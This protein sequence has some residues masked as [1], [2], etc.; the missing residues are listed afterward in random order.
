MS[1]PHLQDLAPGDA[2]L[3]APPS[4]QAA[5]ARRWILTCFPPETVPHDQV[6]Y[7]RPVADFFRTHLL[8]LPKEVKAFTAAVEQAPTTGRWHL[9]GCFTLKK[10]TRMGQVKRLILP[11]LQPHLVGTSRGG[12][13]TTLGTTSGDDGLDSEGGS[14]D[15]V[16]KSARV[17]FER[18]DR[19]ASLQPPISK[20]WAD[21]VVEDRGRR[22]SCTSEAWPEGAEWRRRNGGYFPLFPPEV[23][24]SEDKGPVGTS[25][26]GL[27]EDD[28]ASSRYVR[29]SLAWIHASESQPY[30]K[31]N[32][33]IRRGA[34]MA[35][36]TAD[37]DALLRKHWLG[38]EPTGLPDLRD[39]ISGRGSALGDAPEGG[40]V[41]AELRAT[42]RSNLGRVSSIPDAVLE[43]ITDDA[44][45]P[46]DSGG[47]G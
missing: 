20:E 13:L 40:Q 3:R 35:G 29:N 23:K 19:K 27:H 17:L 32:L 44:E 9:Q 36:P 8:P 45:L 26:R 14:A 21:R 2:T 43:F 28:S 6:R 46:D 12:A 11:D 22:V 38:Q 7:G 18:C 15:P 10:S 16:P 37:G 39:F 31:P 33:S 4:H 24:V 25:G 5:N 41:V 30:E 34:E 42:K 1:Q 47:E